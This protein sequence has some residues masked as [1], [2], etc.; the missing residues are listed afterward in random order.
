MIDNRI[1]RDLIVDCLIIESIEPKSPASAVPEIIHGLRVIRVNDYYFMPNDKNALQDL[2][3]YLLQLHDEKL[4][5][6]ILEPTLILTLFSH[7]LDIQVDSSI[8]SVELPVGALYNLEIFKSIV[9][10]YLIRAHPAFEF[11][12]V[13]V[14]KKRRQIFFQCENFQFRLL[15]ASGPNYHR[16]CR[17]ALGF[18]AEDYDF[19]HYHSGQTMAIDLE[20]GLS[21]KQ[22]EVLTK[23]IFDRFDRYQIGALD[24][25]EFRDFYVRFLDNEVCIELLRTY[26]RYRFRN[27]ELE[28]WWYDVNE[29]K[30]ER[31]ERKK[32]SKLK[33]KD[34]L[35][36]QRRQ[37][38]ENKV[39]CN[40][41]T[42][43]ILKNKLQAEYENKSLLSRSNTISTIF[44]SLDENTDDFS[45]YL[46]SNQENRIGNSM[47]S[48]LFSAPDSYSLSN[49]L[50]TKRSS[51][52]I[53]KPKSSIKSK[54]PKNSKN[55]GNIG[56]SVST[57]ASPTRRQ[58]K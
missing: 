38:F 4:E 32:M 40:D 56:R 2:L 30:R 24:Y 36:R 31:V 34:I 43:R 54:L 49:E 16:S 17:F 55:L 15:F 57:F 7:V 42:F 10:T 3:Q 50:I 11:M 51:L 58:N 53:E 12:T 37:I 14:I 47:Q 9:Q 33:S 28:A 45:S 41:G 23:E 19:S 46:M 13:G 25:E 5:I 35:A 39:L 6:E 8:F 26:A 1:L 22:L 21:Q 27:L 44:E 20:L 29:K 18:S 52:P 48:S